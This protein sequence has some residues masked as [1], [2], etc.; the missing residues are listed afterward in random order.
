MAYE[1]ST[2]NERKQKRREG[3]IRGAIVVIGQKGYNRTKI[4][5]IAREANVAD[6]TIYLY[7]DNKDDL[8]IKVFD[9]TL[10]KRLNQLKEQIEPIEDKLE[11]LDKFLL[12]HTDI[13]KEH[14]EELRFFALEARQ[15]PEFYNRYPDFSPFS[16][17][18]KYVL[19]LCKDAIN[20]QKVRKL[21]PEVLANILLGTLEYNLVSWATGNLKLSIKNVIKQSIDIVHNGI[22]LDK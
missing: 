1:L 11:R 19:E 8:L 22:V 6:G 14:P 5:D 2:L 17:Y 10:E 13:Y 15:S 18:K 7:F 21:A 20:S 3:I 16:E 9:E 12:L 4:I